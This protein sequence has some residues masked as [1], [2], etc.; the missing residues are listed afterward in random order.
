M[1]GLYFI[2][3]S[4]KSKI[5]LL[6][7]IG[8]ISLIFAFAW[9]GIV[10]DFLTIILTGDNFS[11]EYLPHSVLWASV[12]LTFL[13]ALYIACELLTPKKKW[14]IL[15]IFIILASIYEFFIFFDFHRQITI[16]YPEKPGEDMLLGYYTPGSICFIIMVIFTLSYIFFGCFGYLYK[17]FISKGVIR[18]KF[19]LLTVGTTISILSAIAEML[20]A[21]S[22]I[23]VFTRL[24]DIAGSWIV[25]LALKEA[26][27]KPIKEKS[28][29]EVRVEESLFRISKRPDQITEEEVSISKEKKICLV[30]KNELLREIY[31]CP[32]CKTFYCKKCSK[33]L[34]DLENACWVCE[35][36]FDVSKPSKPFKKE[37]QVIDLELLEKSQ[38]KPKLNQKSGG[39]LK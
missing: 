16:V 39:E 9:V 37:E 32:D 12:I 28:K 22:I 18:E 26:T 13:F 29:K 34:S 25:F 3:V 14:Y 19:L 36:P 4:K 6:T 15:S 27:E 33:T 7:I 2:Y 38:K 24:L 23:L 10:L 5:E 35:T 17:A 1:L 8:I 30:C 20:L 31:I 21:R 11:F